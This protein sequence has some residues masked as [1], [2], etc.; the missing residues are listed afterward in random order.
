MSSK[1]HSI[2]G[3]NQEVETGLESMEQWPAPYGF[4]DL[5]SSVVQNHNPKDSSC[6]G[7]SHINHYLRKFCFL[8]TDNLMYTLSQLM[9]FFLDN[10]S[11]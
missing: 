2:T 4:P 11:M 3:G 1:S 6:S 7:I 8:S 9:L 10:A 5:L